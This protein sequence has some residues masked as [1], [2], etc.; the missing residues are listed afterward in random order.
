MPVRAN[1]VL[2]QPIFVRSLRLTNHAHYFLFL[3]NVRIFAK[4]TQEGLNTVSYQLFSS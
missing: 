2:Q 4:P 3:K 1:D